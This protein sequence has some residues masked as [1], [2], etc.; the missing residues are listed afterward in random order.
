MLKHCL[1]RFFLV[2]LSLTSYQSKCQVTGFQPASINYTVEDGLP[3]NE[4]YFIYEDQKGFIWIGT[5][6]GLSKYNG[7]EFENFTLEDGLTDNVVLDIYEDHEGILW[8]YTHNNSIFYYKDNAFHSG[9]I[10]EV[11]QTHKKNLFDFFYTNKIIRIGGDLHLATT[12][13]GKQIIE[14]IFTD[15]ISVVSSKKNSDSLK[16][17]CEFIDDQVFPY[18]NS[19]PTSEARKI[20]F[21][22]D[23]LESPSFQPLGPTSRCRS[24]NN[25]KAT[26]VSRG[27][28]LFT[29]KE[30]STELK[31]FPETIHNIM[32]IDEDIWIS[33]G[34]LTYLNNELYEPFMGFTI[35]GVLKDQSNNY[36]FSTL[37]SGILFYPESRIENLQNT[38]TKDWVVGI[39]RTKDNELY[40]LSRKGVFFHLDETLKIQ[41]IG[42]ISTNLYSSPKHG[43]FVLNGGTFIDPKRGKKKKIFG[44]KNYII[45]EADNLVY[46]L[47]ISE[48]Y[49][50]S[51]PDGNLI[52]RT[53]FKNEDQVYKLTS[54]MDT[55]NRTIYISSLN[56][57]Y[58]TDTSFNLQKIQLDDETKFKINHIIKI[59]TDLWLSTQGRGVLIYNIKNGTSRKIT[60]HD[61][62]NSNNIN[63]LLDD[64]QGHAWVATNNGINIIDI[65]SPEKNIIRISRFNGLISNEIFD[66][67]LKGDYVY[68]ASRKG[69]SRIQLSKFFNRDETPHN[70]LITK[71][72]VNEIDVD[73]NDLNKLTYQQNNLEVHFLSIQL[74]NKENIKY[75][76]RIPELDSNWYYTNLRTARFPNLEHGIYTFEVGTLS[77]NG[78]WSTSIFTH[79]KIQPAFWQT[80]LFKIVI[81]LLIFLILSSALYIR[82]R[83]KSIQHQLQSDIQRYRYQALT[84]QMNPHFVF[85]ALNSIQYFILDQNRRSASKYLSTFAKLIRASFENS[86]QELIPFVDEVD[87]LK[88]YIE[89]ENLRL[90][91]R[92]QVNFDVDQTLDQ[93]NLK[94]PPLIIQPFVENAFLHGL[95]PLKNRIPTLTVSIKNT[96][97]NVSIKIEDNGIGRSAASELK[98]SKNLRRKKSSGV[99]MSEDRL[100]AITQ[101]QKYSRLG[102]KFKIIDKLNAQ[103]QPTGTI[104]KM[105]IPKLT[106]S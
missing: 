88:L 67:E 18:F 65:E 94:V 79:F 7:Y 38:L 55:A 30:H 46:G 19:G 66:L 58:K 17:Y 31:V 51:L 84:S 2:I 76:Y 43:I 20:V 15:S 53:K 77:S 52:A 63:C 85:N 69:I 95:S 16:T 14:N 5:D 3:S 36:W 10:N 103:N 92:V 24:F 8:F 32:G 97:Q 39:E 26:Y 70:L 80:F 25:R 33:A 50:F 83:N 21:S 90:D 48:Y 100:K 12:S 23:H 104:V 68:I 106:Q 41:N 56:E 11:W 49:T 27:K 81:V 6:R 71:I 86:K 101:L 72:K 105:T 89:L 60:T 93:I 98:K 54:F 37:E 64:H 82:N 73:T 4:A 75:R 44:T 28:H 61:G 78:E 1:L 9:K 22:F 40:A 47:G 62:L 57:L 29:V 35:T 96:D 59:N 74:N 13:N 42:S 34:Q 91:N 87:A 45:N 102:Y 99:S